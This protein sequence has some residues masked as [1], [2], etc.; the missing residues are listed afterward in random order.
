MKN[1]KNEQN[2]FT[3]VELVIAVALVGVLSIVALP[4]IMGVSTDARQASVEAAAAVLSGISTNNYIARSADIT[5]GLT[6]INCGSLVTL[7]A[8]GVMDADFALDDSTVTVAADATVDCK[9][10]SVALPVVFANFT[11]RGVL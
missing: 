8:G 1:L 11:Q 3:L 5:K 10:N 2:G 4:K 9:L 7:M 6:S